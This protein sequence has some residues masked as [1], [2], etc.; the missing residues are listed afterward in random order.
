MSDETPDPSQPTCQAYGCPLPGVMKGIGA[1][2]LG[3]WCFVHAR[4]DCDLQS[5]TTRIRERMPFFRALQRAAGMRDWSCYQAIDTYLTRNGRP[6]LSPTEAER[7]SHPTPYRWVVRIRWMLAKECQV[8]ADPNTQPAEQPDGTD[9]SLAPLARRAP[10]FTPV[11]RDELHVE[12][13]DE[14]PM[15]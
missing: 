9:G 2:G 7:A 4:A 3:W 6:E 10:R 12:E 8:K 11:E 15:W 5:T 14:V 13:P 1:P